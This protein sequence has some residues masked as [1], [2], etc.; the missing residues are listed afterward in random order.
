MNILPINL[1]SLATLTAEDSLRFVGITGV[2]LS[3]NDNEFTAEATNGRYVLRATGECVDVS[4]YPEI[5]EVKEAPNG[6]T[7][8]IVPA[9][10]W[11]KTFREAKRVSKKN[12][13]C[14]KAVAV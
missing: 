1:G 6:K 5:Q 12:K 13:H 2:R 7:E 3:I 8:S 4:K 9:K 14:P 10:V 11:Q